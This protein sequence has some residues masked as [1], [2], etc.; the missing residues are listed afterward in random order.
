MCLLQWVT[1]FLVA[2]QKCV[3][4]HLLVGIRLLVTFTGVVRGCAYPL[5]VCGGTS[6]RSKMEQKE[7]AQRV[8]QI[9]HELAALAKGRLPGWV[10]DIKRAE[11]RAEKARLE[12]ELGFRVW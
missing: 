11:L 10:Y 8:Y 7:K 6:T 12:K 9:Q 5:Y 1:H 4:T 3:A 2:T